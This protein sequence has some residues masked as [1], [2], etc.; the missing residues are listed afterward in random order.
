VVLGLLVQ[1]VAA[2]WLSFRHGIPSFTTL[3]IV[4][5]ALRTGGRRGALLGIVAGALTDA[6]AGTAGGWTIADTAVALAVGAVA[7]GFFADGVLPPSFL[8]A[9]AVLV[10]DG[11]FWIVMAMEG[12]PR[13]F[14]TTHLHAA[15]WQ[16][17]LTGLCALVY[18]GLRMRFA[19][20]QTRVERFS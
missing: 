19:D 20:V 16:A 3:A 15:L 12:S 7:R 13:G 11:I 6:F 4:L 2:P 14:G 17:L 18:L 10:R 9:G 5:Y 1:T 8:V